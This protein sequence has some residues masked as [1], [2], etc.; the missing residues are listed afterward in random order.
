MESKRTIRVTGT[1][2]LKIKP[3]TT[4]ITLTLEDVCPQYSDALKNSSE[5]TAALTKTLSMF[6]FSEKDLKTLNFD[7]D[8]EYESYQERGVYK[9]RLVGFRFSHMLKIEFPLDNERLGKIL[10][11]LANCS[12]HPEISISYTVSDPEAEKNMLL[13]KAVTDAVSKAEVLAKAANVSLLSIQGIDYSWGE[14]DLEVR[15]MN[16][17][18]T[19]A[20]AAPSSYDM[21]LEP[22]D[23]D[24]SDTVTVIWEIH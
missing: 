10:Y 2:K 1:G 4:R 18:M 24:V 13:E 8:S 3:D 7:I 11:S 6:G 14:L 23:I 9:K 20:D 19:V 15:P 12:V 17:L 21:N 5:S 22:D 16:R